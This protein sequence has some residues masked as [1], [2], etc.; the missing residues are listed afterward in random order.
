MRWKLQSQ[1]PSNG[2]AQEKEQYCIL[3]IIVKY[4]Y[5]RT[6][7]FKVFRIFLNAKI[8]NVN[9]DRRFNERLNEE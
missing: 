3:E 9:V 8:L 5:V 6:F 2:Q 1:T 7:R 4:K